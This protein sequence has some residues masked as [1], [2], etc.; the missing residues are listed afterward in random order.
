M[1]DVAR[2]MI[3]FLLTFAALTFAP[4]ALIVC[5]FLLSQFW[6]FRFGPMRFGRRWA[7]LS[8]VC[9]RPGCS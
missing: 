9:R 4:L 3:A 7:P 2:P 5:F 1:R 8:S 6:S